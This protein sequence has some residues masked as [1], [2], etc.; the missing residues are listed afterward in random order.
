MPCSCQRHN[1]PC[2]D[3]STVTVVTLD[4]DAIPGYTVE[5]EESGTDRTVNIQTD[6]DGYWLFRIWL[7]DGADV[8]DQETLHPPDEPGA[9]SF[10]KVTN[11]AGLCTFTIRSTIPSTHYVH[12]ALVG[13]VSVSAPVTA[14]V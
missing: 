4:G 7:T 8:T 2:P 9:A 6:I 5:I 1:S 3:A 14:G 11:S 12:A 13:A 10:F